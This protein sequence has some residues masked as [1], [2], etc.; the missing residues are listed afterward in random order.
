[1]FPA[2]FK[3]CG[4][5][6]FMHSA[7]ELHFFLGK[8]DTVNSIPGALNC[9]RMNVN[10]AYLEALAFSHFVAQVGLELFASLASFFLYAGITE[11]R[12]FFFNT[13]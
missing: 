2:I 9:W 6:P 3:L 1:M 7:C 8:P 5:R 11:N 4:F 13:N 12:R 10:G